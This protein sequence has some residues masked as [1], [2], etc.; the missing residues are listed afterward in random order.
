M[1]HC[2]YQGLVKLFLQSLKLQSMFDS[3]ATPLRYDGSFAGSAVDL[4]IKKIIYSDK[5]SVF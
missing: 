3:I 2:L 5:T 4:F 1:K